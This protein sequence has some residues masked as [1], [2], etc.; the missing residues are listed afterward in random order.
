MLL[1]GLA[2]AT[3][4]EL[5]TDI[6]GPVEITGVELDPQIIEVGRRLLRHGSAQLDAGGCRRPRLADA[7]AGRRAV[8]S[9]RRRRL[10]SALYTLPPG[11]GQDFFELVRD[12]LRDDG[13]LA[14]NVGRTNTNF[15][16]VDALTATLEQVF[17]TVYAI[18]EPGPPATL[19]NALVIATMQPVAL[20]EVRAPFRGVAID[21]TGRG[22]STSALRPPS[23]CA[24]L[25]H[26]RTR[27]LH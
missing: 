11:D 22:T 21:A 12:H 4:S 27:H 14:I 19:A 10:S 16:L 23:R 8:G 9:D 7:A 26:R 18:D 1:I 20:D 5:M 25:Q 3:V 13:V 17:P 6:Y 15:A 24:P 2:A